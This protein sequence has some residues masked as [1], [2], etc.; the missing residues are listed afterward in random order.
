MIAALLFLA[1]IAPVAEEPKP[2]ATTIAAIRANPKKFDG[3]VVRL[4]GYVN[5]CRPLSCGIE[6][7][8]ASASAGAGQ[9]LS[10]ATDP[11]FDATIKPLLPT[12]VEFDARVD[13]TCLIPSASNSITVCADRVPELTI[14]T[15]RGIVSPEPPPFEKP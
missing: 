6:E 7:R 10:I 13:A 4:H 11:K 1:Q 8:L 14:V 2:V 15:L 3:R 12:Y 9:R 5:S